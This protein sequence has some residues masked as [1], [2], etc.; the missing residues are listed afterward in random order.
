MARFDLS[1]Y[2]TVAERLDML[3]TTY[4]DARIVTE[5]LTTSQDRENKM[6]VV[7][8]TLFLTDSDQERNLPKATGHAF[9]IDGGQGANQTSALENAETSATGRCLSLANWNGNKNVSSLASRE[10]M[11]KVIRVMEQKAA[12]YRLSAE[13]SDNVVEL[14]TIYA[15]A[16]AAGID[17]DTLKWIE[18]KARGLKVSDEAVDK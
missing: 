7:K 9:E 4:P 10:E 12:E 15:Q 6:W 17:V 11:Q 8:A 3:Y 1:Q 16:Q 5:N 18:G 14:R 2:A 13:K